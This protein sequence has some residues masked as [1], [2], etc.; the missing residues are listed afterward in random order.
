M[1]SKRACVQI[2]RRP[3]CLCD[4]WAGS[5]GS[6]YAGR[7]RAREIAA[8]AP[9]QN[10]VINYGVY[11]GVDKSQSMTIIRDRAFL[12]LKSIKDNYEGRIAYYDDE[13]VQKHL[14]GAYVG[15]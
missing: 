2:W 13:M 9:I 3:V 15:E 1:F 8:L 11:Q 4:L 14:Q 12:A 5:T 6:P 10:L 7:D